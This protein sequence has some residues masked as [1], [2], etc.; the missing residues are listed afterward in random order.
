M[1]WQASSGNTIKLLYFR[2]PGSQNSNIMPFKLEPFCQ[3]IDYSF[4]TPVETWRKSLMRNQ[5]FHVCSTT[6]SMPLNL[7]KVGLKIAI[8]MVCP[9]DLVSR[10]SQSKLGELEFT[11]YS[12]KHIL[13]SIY[14]IIQIYSNH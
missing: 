6:L 8:F 2:I 7:E 3:L 14:L 10:T 9:D 5:N 11:S 4:P 12:M 1:H 13:R